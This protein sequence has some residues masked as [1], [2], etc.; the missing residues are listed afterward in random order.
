VDV[1]DDPDDNR[2]I[3]CALTAR[4][5]YIVTNNNALRRIGKY[6]DIDIVRVSEFLEPGR[7]GSV[8]RHT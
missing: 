6:G 3:E 7:R 2:I 1:V 4:S 8:S 5:D